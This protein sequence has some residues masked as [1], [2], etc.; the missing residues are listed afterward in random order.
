M[1]TI[2]HGKETEVINTAD[3]LNPNFIYQT[4]STKLLCDIVNGKKEKI[5][6]DLLERLKTDNDFLIGCLI[7]LYHKQT[8]NTVHKN[9]CGFNSY[10]ASTLFNISKIY[11]D[12]FLLTEKQINYVRRTI[13]KYKNQLSLD[14]KPLPAHIRK[15][16]V[17]TQDITEKINTM[18]K[19]RLEV[20]T[21][22]NKMIIY[23]THPDTDIWKD[24]L[25]K[26]QT[27]PGK[28]Y[29]PV[30]KNWSATIQIDSIIRLK[31]WGF[32]LD[33][34]LQRIYDN[35]VLTIPKGSIN[36]PEL[37]ANLLPFQEEGVLFIDSRKGRALVADEMGLGK[38]IQS[39]AWTALHPKIRPVVVLCPASLKLN[40]QRELLK[41][42]PN[43][44]SYIINGRQ[45][46]ILP[47]I[48]FIIVNYSI[49]NKHIESI[50]E[51]KPRICIIDECHKLINPEA[52]RTV[53]SKD[54]TQNIPYVIGLTGTPIRN[55]TKEFFN[56]LN[57]LK[58]EQWF[59]FENFKRVYTKREYNGW[60]WDYVGSQNENVL[61]DILTQTVMIRRKKEEVLPQLPNKTYS[62]IPVALKER[63]IY[64]ELI[65]GINPNA[66]PKENKTHIETIKRVI[67][68]Y[69]LDS[70]FNWVDDFLSNGEKLILFTY[71]HD[72]MDAF[73]E[74]YKNIGVYYDGRSTLVKKQ[75]MVDRFNMD[76]SCK[77]F[78]GQIATAVGYNLTISSH[79][80]HVE[81]GWVPSD[82]DQATDRS[83]R[84]G[85]KNAV[86]VYYFIAF[87]TIEEK[88]IKLLDKKRKIV[89]KTIDG[90]KE[91]DIE[92][93]QD[94]IKD[95][96]K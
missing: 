55:N 26:I 21:E 14:I 6:I 29:R 20:I 69:K 66:S 51:M 79:V 54:L 58:P 96:R 35:N 73:A 85:Q 19:E 13:L 87:D 46:Q 32:S 12:G 88:I 44:S 95:M 36:I 22:K 50:L 25:E 37:N 33:E 77:L 45:P 43:E 11:L 10:D 94:L 82:M 31:Q 57:I 15:P 52:T 27:L 40:W 39:I 93:I 49:L 68:Q 67:V 30:Q 7:Y 72:T 24:L 48:K 1:I 60:G 90:K 23:F 18:Y 2:V 61:H 53:A 42:L 41:F 84:I 70:I 59:S 4:I 74:K 80:G 56:I 5:M 91:E 71:H 16:T 62:I 92:L 3:E 75:A 47:P 28:K 8:D 76:E 38:T 83:H 78:V 17:V 89:D 63:K 34:N 64:N 65:N 81:F 9:G 86:N